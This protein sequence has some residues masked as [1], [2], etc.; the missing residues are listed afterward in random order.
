MPLSYRTEARSYGIGFTMT[1]PSADQSDFESIVWIQP[2]GGPNETLEGE[3]KGLR[4][5][6]K[7]WI[8]SRIQ[9][10]TR[11]ISGRP[12]GIALEVSFSTG[13]AISRGHPKL[14]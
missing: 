11:D 4:E 5:E 12:D 7:A 10:T 6:A 8:Y 9:T 2:F 1:D 3:S 13:C 14:R